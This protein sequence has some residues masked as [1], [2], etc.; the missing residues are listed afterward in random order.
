MAPIGFWFFVAGFS[1]VVAIYTGDARAWL[2]AIISFAGLVCVGCA[3]GAITA[4]KGRR[5]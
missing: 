1:I 3:T 4:R 2:V 5:G